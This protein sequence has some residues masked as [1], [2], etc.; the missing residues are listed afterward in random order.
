VEG[1][2]AKYWSDSRP[3]RSNV[4]SYREDVAAR[5]WDVSSE[6][7]GAACDLARRAPAAARVGQSA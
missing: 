6:L 2:T 7:T 5:L 4:E 1:V 3:V